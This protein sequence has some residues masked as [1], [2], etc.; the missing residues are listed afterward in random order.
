[1]K[2][3]DV[4]IGRDFETRVEETFEVMSMPIA[5]R[6][7]VA[8]HLGEKLAI[9]VD[10]MDTFFKYFPDME[11][12]EIL[13]TDNFDV[14]KSVD[15]SVVPPVLSLKERCIETIRLERIDTTPLKH[16]YLPAIKQAIQDFPEQRWTILLPENIAIFQFDYVKTP[17]MDINTEDINVFTHNMLTKMLGKETTLDLCNQLE[18]YAL[19]DGNMNRNLLVAYE[20]T[21]MWL[22]H[23]YRGFLRPYIVNDSIA[24]TTICTRVPVTQNWLRLMRKYNWY[25]IVK[26]LVYHEVYD[27]EITCITGDSF[28]T[29]YLMKCG[30]VESNPGP[31]VLSTLNRLNNPKVKC[32]EVQGW[33]SIPNY[34]GKITSFLSEQLPA[35]MDRFFFTVEETREQFHEDVVTINN[36]TLSLRDKLANLKYDLVK[37][38]VLVLTVFLLCLYEQYTLSLITAILGVIGLFSDI[39]RDLMEWLRDY[40]YPLQDESKVEVQLD[41]GSAIALCGPAIL[42][43]VAFYGINKLPKDSEIEMFSKKIFSIDKGV[44]GT[45]H[46]FEHFAKL[47][48]CCQEWV[49]EKLGIVEPGAI[50]TFE[51]DV[52]KWHKEIEFWSVLKN[53]EDAKKDPNKALII[54]KL[55]LTGMNHKRQATLLNMDR[56]I[57]DILNSGIIAASKLYKF[58]EESNAIGGGTRFK[59]LG[60]ALFGESQIGKTTMVETLSQ[61]LLYEMGHRDVETYRNEIYSRQAETEFF[62]GYVNQSIIIVDDAF[63]VRD[64]QTKPNAEIA[65]TIRMINEFPHHLHMAILQDKNTYNTSRVVLWTINN[66]N[67]QT[68]SLS[69]PKAFHNRLMENAYKVEPADHVVKLVKDG[70][71]Q[72]Q[73]LLDQS[74]INTADGPIDL[75]IYKITKYERHERDGGV[76][77]YPV[78]ESMNYEQFAE[79]C[80]ELYKCRVEKHANKT[81]FLNARFTQLVKQPRKIAVQVGSPELIKNLESLE[82]KPFRTCY[83]KPPVKQ[84]DAAAYREEFFDA[85][86]MSL[87][88]ALNLERKKII[89]E[90]NKLLSRYRT[91]DLLLKIGSTILLVYGIYKTCRELFSNNT[92]ELIEKAKAL[93]IQT[94]LKYAHGLAKEPE[95]NKNYYL[96]MIRQKMVPNVIT[97]ILSD[98]KFSWDELGDSFEVFNRINLLRVPTEEEEAI[99]DLFFDKVLLDAENVAK[100]EMISSGSQPLN[101]AKKI[102]VEHYLEKKKQRNYTTEIVSSGAQPLH[103][104]QKIQIETKPMPKEEIVTQACSDLA[105][106]QEGRCLLDKNIYKCLLN[107][108]HVL[109]NVIVV[110]GHVVLMPYHYIAWLQMRGVTRKDTLALNC[111]NNVPTVS[112]YQRC[113][114]NMSTIFDDELKLT[115]NVLRIKDHDADI[116]AA[117]IY[118]DPR[119]N[120]MH[121]HGDITPKLITN[122]EL[123]YIMPSTMAVMFGYNS[124]MKHFSKCEKFVQELTPFD[125]PIQLNMDGQDYMMLRCGYS[126]SVASEKGDCGAALMVLSRRNNRKWI[127]M[128]VAGSSNNEG[129]SIKLTQE[130]IA[131]HLKQL[132]INIKQKLITAEVHNLSIEGAMCPDGDFILNGVTEIPLSASSVTKIEPSLIYGE[133]STPI[134]K[135][136]YLRPFTNYEGILVDPALLGL[137]K[138][139]GEQVLC[140]KYILN[141]VTAYMKQRLMQQHNQS[142]NLSTYARVMTYEEAIQGA[143]DDFMRAVCRTT[144]PGYPW[145]SDPKYNTTLPGKSAWMGR[146]GTFDFVSPR[147]IELRQAVENL[148]KSCL[149]GIQ[150]DVICA[151][152]LKDERRPIAK[153]EQG[154]TRLFAACP[155]HFVVLFRKY[156]LGFSA[157]IM[158]NRIDNEVAVGTNPFSFDWGKI[159]RRL[160][161]KGE[162]V[163]A[164][165]FSNF[166]GSLNSMV[167]WRIFDVIEHWYKMN[168]PKYSIDHYMIRQTLWAHIVNSVHI[169]KNTLYQ[170]TH[171]QPSGNPFTVIINSIYNSMILRCAYLTCMRDNCK[172][173]PRDHSLYTLEAF[174][175]HIAVITYGD[176]NCLNISPF[177]SKYFNQITLTTALKKWG[178]D[179]TDEGKTG[180]IV[181]WRTLDNIAFL[182]RK[183][184]FDNHIN[185]WLAPLDEAV[186]WEMLNWK[187]TNEI[188]SKEALRV[189]ISTA[190]REMALHGKDKYDQFSALLQSNPNVRKYR[191]N[192]VIPT[193]A[194]M[195]A[196][197]E[198]MDFFLD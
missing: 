194:S 12:N 47:W 37:C 104:Q 188:S 3:I 178:H 83:L 173:D 108:N 111:I 136:A 50:T 167:L 29:K 106:L 117:L 184:I 33:M 8:E 61:D 141:E 195:L 31:A 16:F 137:K 151:D 77:Y 165:D 53:K 78:G 140:D 170:W 28:D 119:N 147:A 18:Y 146:D 69:Y 148:E 175:K 95:A 100:V 17:N 88:E 135:P 192:I 81:E 168:D 126:Y 10:D 75:S 54:S 13:Y 139:G 86:E 82:E 52:M 183:F 62:D 113:T 198:D 65:E 154:K 99:Y 102:A 43:I 163:L 55:Y 97:C 44:T 9:K 158:H 122:E 76:V 153:V 109:G 101:K 72:E 24:E 138:A 94:A 189:S 38:F 149:A 85:R 71:G 182:K 7:P 181:E 79:H 98:V 89:E 40:F 96:A 39:P 191:L 22:V 73:K 131:T 64:S 42:S 150:R 63:A 46:M 127:G 20:Y 49:S 120:I 92:I 129:Y 103:K 176:D 187:R 164:G 110:K 26:Q 180:E 48:S 21:D 124:D 144:S 172:E 35:L 84:F 68:P 59:P 4:T 11:E 197:I 34:L 41:A 56:R 128:H 80:K 90:N 14:R 196:T 160:Q 134:T 123:G 169:Y 19:L 27:E 132:E 74:K 2:I 162:R 116:D 174:D 125:T 159:A 121:N 155:Q 107:N 193:Y 130:L 133:F 156:Y 15:A 186:I 45:V 6:M 70:N 93:D 1:M 5:T 57:H 179:Y 91:W 23:F 177:I 114:I 60:I 105:T 112:K 66:I 143:N 152:T 185:K 166:D 118:V 58:V 190:A 161:T 157:W 171:S 32:A 36:T 115:S 145:N 87:G 142:I 30:D 25:D 51:Q 67:I